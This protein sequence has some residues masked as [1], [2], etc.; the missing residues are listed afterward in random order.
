MK[1]S[2]ILMFG[3]LLLMS[4]ASYKKAVKEDSS[5]TSTVTTSTTENT[6]A[7][8]TS[9]SESS[10]TQVTTTQ[11]QVDDSTETV[12]ITHTTWYDTSKTDSSGV[13]P[14]LKEETITSTTRHGKRS[15]KGSDER[16]DSDEKSQSQTD[17]QKSAT[18]EE[19]AESVL[20]S[21]KTKD[22]AASE[23]KQV[24]YFSW[25]LFGLAFVIITA[26]LAYWVFTKYRQ[27]R[28]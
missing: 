24:Q 12:T 5:Q 27:R 23:T 28:G 10:V 8:T 20:T 14:V 11:E 6:Q 19:S 1:R 7:V 13:S 22:V 4:C 25:A 16:K 21:S 26:I 2:V 17:V 15:K 18:K 3:L 9:T